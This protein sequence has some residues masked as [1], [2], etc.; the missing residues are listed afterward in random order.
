MMGRLLLPDV[1][2]LKDDLSDEIGHVLASIANIPTM[3]AEKRALIAK[4]CAMM[5]A[6]GYITYEGRYLAMDAGAFTRVLHVGDSCCM[7]VPMT[8][9]GHLEPFRGKFIRIVYVAS[10]RGRS[11]VY[12][13][14]ELAR[15]RGFKR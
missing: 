5:E 15:R 10:S 12:M 13:A 3:T 9:R 6:K 7:D 2:L 14:G 1:G 4:A 8:K 11:K